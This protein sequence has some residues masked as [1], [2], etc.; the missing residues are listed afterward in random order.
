M[1]KIN[2]LG[3]TG[4]IGRQTLD[5]VRTHPEAFQLIAVSAGRNVDSMRAIIQEFKPL[6]VSVQTQGD[7]LQ[8]HS[9]FPFLKVLYGME[10]LVEVA[11]HEQGDIV[12]NAVMGSVGLVPTLQAIAA[13]K[14][15]ALANK[16]T[17]VTAGHL[18]MDA[19]KKAGV[20]LIPVDSEHSAIFQA[21]QGENFKNI[22]KIIL[23]ASGG[24][25]RDRTRDEL[26]SVTVADALNHPNWSMGAKI[27]IDSAT[28]MNKGLEVIEA[29]WLFGLPYD[30]IDVIIHYE[31][32]IHSLVEFHDTSV[33]AQLGTPDMRLPI[34][35]ALTYPDR[36]PLHNA[37]RLNLVE[38]AK[39]NFKSVDFDRFPLLRLAYEAG[40]AGGT[41]TTVLN[42]ANEE[43]VQLFLQEKVTFLDIERIV[44]E[45]LQHHTV[46]GNPDLATIQQI[47][48]ETRRAVLDRNLGS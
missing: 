40:V 1:R 44:E 43:A 18:V 17:L 31:S 29:H 32:V 10:G 42:A 14:D 34:Q 23:T 16:E 8:L 48:Q 46:I 6:L 11:T 13:G 3:A 47:D 45:S 19:A 26:K 24:S 22:S 7:A 37:E 27:T 33:M 20:K 38:V 25:F 2:L 41:L 5:V 28:L 35:Y 21:L 36:L 9:E 30:Q 39:L 12:V 4:S 15:I